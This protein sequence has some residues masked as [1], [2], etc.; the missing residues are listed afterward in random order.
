MALYDS[1]E[2]LAMCK[3]L[4]AR[5][6]LEEA[7]GPDASVDDMWYALL[8]EAEQHY[9]PVFAAHYPGPMYEPPT[10]MVTHDGGLTYELPN[11]IF[12]LGQMEIYARKNGDLLVPGAYWD[13]HADYV[14]EG[15]IIRMTRGRARVFADGPYARYV[16]PPGVIDAE[17]DSTIQPPFARRV[18]VYHA[19]ALWAARGGYQDPAVWEA[20]EQQALF[21][22]PLIPGDIGILGQ[23]K[24]Q[25]FASGLA[26]HAQ[27][28]PYRWWRPA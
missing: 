20:R 24:T 9:K 11:G 2:L 17:T 6:S 18:L 23:L 1:A 8:T 14:Q 15:A 5:P 12:P 21:G 7:G 28:G 19:L 4:A 22:N 16:T 10:L 26:A 13:P 27:A 25:N 3:R